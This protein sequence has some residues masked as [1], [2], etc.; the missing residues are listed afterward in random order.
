[1][2]LRRATLR[3]WSPVECA[4]PLECGAL[5]WP[6]SVSRVAAPAPTGDSS[7]A[8]AALHAMLP[9]RPPSLSLFSLRARGSGGVA[10]SVDGAS[11]SERRDGGRM[12]MRMRQ[13]NGMAGAS[14]ARGESSVRSDRPEAREWRRSA[15]GQQRVAARMT[16]RRVGGTSHV[17]WDAC[18]ADPCRAMHAAKARKL[19]RDRVRL[20]ADPG[21]RAARR[22]TR[23]TMADA[24]PLYVYPRKGSRDESRRSIAKESSFEKFSE[25]VTPIDPAHPYSTCIRLSS[26]DRL[27]RGAAR[28]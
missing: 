11:S 5:R 4:P 14:L 1:M 15:S 3:R 27:V 26:D 12:G 20:R 17:D 24:M 10:C 7:T 22:S 23:Q 8:C 28:A 9:L 2:S 13:G 16:A 18:A 19:D 21:N 25:R 6:G